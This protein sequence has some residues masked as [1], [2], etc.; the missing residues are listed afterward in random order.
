MFNYTAPVYSLYP[1]GD[2]GEIACRMEVKME[3]FFDSK[4][5]FDLE[6][7]TGSHQSD[8]EQTVQ[9][10]H[11]GCKVEKDVTESASGFAYSP[12]PSPPPPRW[13]VPRH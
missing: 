10:A 8:A 12:L 9:P 11:T 7:C 13:N 2:E 4:K 6:D 3:D 5:Y 1:E